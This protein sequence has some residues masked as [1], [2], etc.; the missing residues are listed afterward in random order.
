MI[1]RRA[2][3]RQEI[4]K[5][6]ETGPTEEDIATHKKKQLAAR[7]VGAADDTV[8]ATNPVVAPVQPPP[9]TMRPSVR[10]ALGGLELNPNASDSEEE[11]DRMVVPRA[12]LEP[13][14]RPRVPQLGVEQINPPAPVNPPQTHFVRVAK[15]GGK[16]SD[17]A[18]ASTA[19]VLTPP[20]TTG[21]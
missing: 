13:N 18:L 7:T 20:R 16:L 11:M 14:V 19:Q 10:S 6:M 17:R 1:K 9:V 2:F 8:D 3:Q 5:Y 4:R 21:V 12:P 15:G